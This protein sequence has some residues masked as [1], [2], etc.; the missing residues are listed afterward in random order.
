MK[1][2]FNKHE[3]VF[4][5][6][7]S[8]RYMYMSE[9]NGVLMAFCFFYWFSFP[10]ILFKKGEKEKENALGV[11]GYNCPS[12]THPHSHLVDSWNFC[13]YGVSFPVISVLPLAPFHSLSPFS[14]FNPSPSLINK[15]VS[16][17]LCLQKGVKQVGLENLTIILMKICTREG[18]QM[19]RK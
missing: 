1:E 14:L 16:L 2:P 11:V 13:R 9:E 19:S 6:Q 18:T 15:S 10:F 12:P 5:P 3:N 7:R 4:Q 17:L 8:K